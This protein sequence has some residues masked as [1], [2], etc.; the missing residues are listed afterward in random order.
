[1][2][3]CVLDLETSS[4][5]S[6]KRVGNPLDPYNEITIVAIKESYSSFPRVVYR[7]GKDLG[8]K[9]SHIDF[10]K[11]FDVIVG[12]NIKFDLL[13]L[14]ENT[15]LQSFIRRGGKIWDTMLAEWLLQGQTRLFLEK[16]NLNAVSGLYGGTQKDSY[17][18]DCFEAGIMTK[19][20]PDQ[21]R[22]IEYAKN[23]VLNTEK[24]FINQYK[25]A[26]K[27]GQLS[28][29]KSYNNHLLAVCEIEFNG[30]R[31]DRNKALSM[32][33]E[34]EAL[35]FDLDRNI[36]EIVLSSNL[37]N[38][39]LQF[40]ISSNQHISCILFGGNQPIIVD[41]P[42]GIFYKTGS[43]VGQEKTKKIKKFVPVAS[44]GMLTLE[45]WRGK[46]SGIY[47]VKDDTLKKLLTRKGIS[48]LQQKFIELLLEYREVAKRVSTYFENEGRG[49]LAL[50]HPD[51]CLHGE[52]ISIVTPTGRLACSNP[53]MQN[54]PE[55]IKPMFVPRTTDSIFMEFDYSQ[56][57]VR[58]QAY[59]AQ[60]QKMIEDIEGG[61]DFHRLRLS[62]ALDTTYEDVINVKDYDYKRKTIAKPISFQ[63]AYGAH[64]TTISNRT[65][66]PLETVGKVFE[67]ENLRYP[68]IEEY[69]EGLVR[70]LSLNRQV[71]TSLQPIKNKVSGGIEYRESEALAIGFIKTITGKVHW[72]E[73]KAVLTD[74]GVWRWFNMP[75]IQNYPV[76]GLANDLFILAVYEV[77]KYL[78]TLP[79]DTAIIVNEIHDSILIECK[80]S[81]KELVKSEICT[82]MSNVDKKFESVYG[83]KWNVPL[84]VDVKE[85]RFW[86]EKVY[87]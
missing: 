22:V 30:M 35:L 50:L 59:L 4:R 2:K 54:I 31:V 87:V 41:E 45:E 62:Y 7:N 78:L 56:L 81:K 12:H 53:N 73:E 80:E 29:I 48:K 38:I 52:Y 33:V 84:K 27:Y 39:P 70:E 85:M 47:S 3:Y 83:I 21:E 1:M 34:Q 82:I 75:D 66:I 40:N 79:K 6:Y 25:K 65:G 17:V 68:E 77:Y 64:S 9:T 5:D 42:T 16:F 58:V 32:K 36:K 61:L 18:S 8:R 71:T 44:F 60:S 67:K 13:Y 69:Y 23:D 37:W 26:K 57:E 10:I 63:K 19:N 55:S 72:F 43:R 76:Q 14:W 74:R 20:I 15:H 49:N 24:V 86:G 28:L 11:E 46:T 51:N